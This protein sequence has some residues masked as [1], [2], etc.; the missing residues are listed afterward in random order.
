MY[1]QLRLSPLLYGVGFFCVVTKAFPSLTNLFVCSSSF[2][3]KK[4][5]V[6]FYRIPT[7]PLHQLVSFNFGWVYSGYRHSQRHLATALVTVGPSIVHNTVYELQ[8]KPKNKKPGPESNKC[9]VWPLYVQITIHSPK[10]VDF[11]DGFRIHA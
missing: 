7:R 4:N 9:V 6:A 5:Q 3:K 8:W 11:Q 2:D 1:V 10:I